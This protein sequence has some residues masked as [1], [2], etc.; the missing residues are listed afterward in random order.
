[1]TRRTMPRRRTASDLFDRIARMMLRADRGELVTRA[2]LA[3]EWD[4][5]PRA[6]SYALVH[7]RQ[8]YGIRFRFIDVL[9]ERGYTLES[10]G[11][12]NLDALRRRHR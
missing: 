10:A 6:V 2:D 8:R 11:I 5:T 4:C 1:M 7:A 3:E 9:G 12:I